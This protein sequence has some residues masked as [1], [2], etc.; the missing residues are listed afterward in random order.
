MK[1]AP[2]AKASARKSETSGK[3][4]PAG[5]S[6]SV[7]GF[8]FP[9]VIGHRGAARHAPENTL[10]G[11]RAAACMGVTCVEFDVRLTRD[12]VPVLFHDDTVERTTDGQGRLGALTLAQVR[13]LD[14]G[15]WFAPRFASEPVPTLVEAI[16]ALARLDLAANIELK[17]EEAQG[18]AMARAVLGVLRKSW[19][20]ERPRPLLSSFDWSALA[21]LAAEDAAWPRG[22]LIR[23]PRQPDW[24]AW[25]VRIGAA[26]IHC[27]ARG[28]DR[29]GVETLLAAGLP[30]AVYTVNDARRARNLWKWG[31]DAIFTDDPARLLAAR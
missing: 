5:P 6:F 13:R 14:A 18:A 22:L 4:G 20:R 19:P 27:G 31:V 25:A 26:A 23:N 7:S 15:S 1:A 2:K 28:L 21:T 11:L 12:G 10:A 16:K 17:P 24:R 8:V 30:V 3:G 9:P 29:A